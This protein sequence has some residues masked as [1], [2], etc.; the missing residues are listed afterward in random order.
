MK[1]TTDYRCGL[2]LTGPPGGQPGLM[3]FDA[4]FQCQLNK[5][6][7]IE[8][9]GPGHPIQDVHRVAVSPHG[10]SSVIYST[11]EGFLRDKSF[12]MHAGGLDLSLFC[13]STRQHASL[14]HSM[15]KISNRWINMQPRRS[16]TSSSV[17]R[18]TVLSPLQLQAP[19]HS[20]LHHL[21]LSGTVRNRIGMI[22]DV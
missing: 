19:N 22:H 16:C 4:Q 5:N 7:A 14:G 15:M 6:N 21:A 20:I 3:N 2:V 8:S 17:K 12:I 10:K 9:L 1:D 11:Q 13:R 18:W